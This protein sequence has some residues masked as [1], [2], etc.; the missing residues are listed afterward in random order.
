MVSR[1]FEDKIK[2]YFDGGVQSQ[3]PPETSD[4]IKKDMLRI[5]SRVDRIKMEG[6]VLAG[7]LKLGA[8]RVRD[9]ETGQFGPLQFHM[10]HDNYVLG[11][12]SEHAAKLFANFVNQ[13]S[14]GLELSTPPP[15]EVEGQSG[16]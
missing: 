6:E 13:T 5:A 7:G 9:P 15:A 12:M 1:W 14:P 2:R 3:L 11:V 4:A 10:T 16:S 8:Y